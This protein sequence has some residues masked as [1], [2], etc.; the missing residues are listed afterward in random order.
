VNTIYYLCPDENVPVG[1]IKVL[2]RHVDVL[3]RNSFQAAIVHR[4]KGFRATWFENH[5]RVEY[6]G[7]INPDAFDF[8]VVPEVNGPR[9]TNVFPGAKKVIFNQNAYYT[10][11][12]Y[13]LDPKDRVTAYHDPNLVGVMATSE[14][15]RDYLAYVFPDLKVHRIHSAV[16]EELFRFRPLSAKQN[17][18]SFMARKHPEEA[19]Q[20]INILKFRNTLGGM[21]VGKIEGRSE[22]DVAQILEES[23]IFL[24]F[25]YPK[26]LPAAPVEAMMCG[27]LVI[28]YDGFGGREFYDSSY[29]WPVPVGDIL[30]MARTV[31]AVLNQHRTA[32]QDLQEKADAAR[33]AVRRRYS[34][35]REEHDILEFWDDVMFSQGRDAIA[36]GL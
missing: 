30:G 23:L 13:S 16:D 26:G 32:P 6:Y 7:K 12:G 24:S 21:D 9:A 5:T 3:N 2:Y 19:R 1:G 31:E 27:C 11:I 17:R 28:G 10:F 36:E 29:C 25:G 8:I 34:L 22:R 15:S 14:D 35:E 4:K 18:I 20:V 33:E